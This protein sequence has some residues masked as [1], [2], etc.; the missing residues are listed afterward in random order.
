MHSVIFIVQDAR[1]RITGNYNLYKFICLGS[2]W[3]S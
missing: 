3:L 2:K 1:N